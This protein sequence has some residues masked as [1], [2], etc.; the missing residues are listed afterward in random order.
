[1]MEEDEKGVGQCVRKKTCV[2]YILI[3]ISIGNTEKGV[4][5]YSLATKTFKYFQSIS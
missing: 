4:N 2:M 5:Q 3:Q 1:M